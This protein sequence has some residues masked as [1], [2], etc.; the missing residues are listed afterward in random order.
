MNIQNVYVDYNHLIISSREINLNKINATE[1]SIST[2]SIIWQPKKKYYRHGKYDLK[3]YPAKNV[4]LKQNI[5]LRKVED[6]FIITIASI[7]YNVN[8]FTFKHGVIYDKEND[9]G[10]AEIYRVDKAIDLSMIWNVSH[11]NIYVD[12]NLT[13]SYDGTKLPENYKDEEHHLFIFTELSP[14]YNGTE[15]P[16]SLFV[17]DYFRYYYLFYKNYRVESK[18]QH[19]E[20]FPIRSLCKETTKLSDEKLDN[21][22]SGILD[23]KYLIIIGVVIFL[24]LS[25][26][27]VISIFAILRYRK[28]KTSRQTKTSKKF[29]DY[30]SDIEHDDNYYSNIQH[31]NNYYAVID[32]NHR[33]S[34][35]YLKIYDEQYEEITRVETNNDEIELED[36]QK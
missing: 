7:T 2:G 11:I 33:E 32:E 4:H 18:I 19:D 26:S 13:Y 1:T 34:N 10:Y 3:I 21:E 20:L 28:L 17:I 5:I 25:I 16:C 36:L 35:D 14:D 8:S 27:V 15:W 22:K 6:N 24:T 31:D 23:A 29:H 12:N 30:Y 9:D